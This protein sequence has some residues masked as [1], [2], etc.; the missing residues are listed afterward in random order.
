MPREMQ[1]NHFNT[2][3]LNEV[4]QD[5]HTCDTGDRLQATGIT[6][7]H[8]G[9]GGQARLLRAS[10]W[11]ETKDQTMS[12]YH[13]LLARKS[14][15]GP[16]DGP[17]LRNRRGKEQ[18]ALQDMENSSTTQ[19]GFGEKRYIRRGPPDTVSLYNASLFGRWDVAKT[20]PI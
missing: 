3:V 8:F 19:D 6:N 18:R 2:S 12:H 17:Q 10:R 20:D 4:N 11:A 5:K 15:G 7:S 9:K 14:C 16:R 13:I 1:A